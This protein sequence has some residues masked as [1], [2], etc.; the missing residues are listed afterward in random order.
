[1]LLGNV[2]NPY[3]Y[4]NNCDLYAQFSVYEAD[5]ITCKEVLVF[6]KRMVLSNIDAFNY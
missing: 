5:P 4:M 6:N 1:M 3:K 2:L